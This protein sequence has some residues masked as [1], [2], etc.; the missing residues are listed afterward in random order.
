MSPPAIPA[1][2]LGITYKPIDRPM[3]QKALRDP[4]HAFIAA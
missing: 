3:Q 2:N 1:G 4:L